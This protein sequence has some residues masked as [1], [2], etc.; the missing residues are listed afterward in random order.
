MASFAYVVSRTLFLRKK[1]KY[2]CLNLWD[3]SEWPLFSRK[4][5]GT[6]IKGLFYQKDKSISFSQLNIAKEKYTFTRF[7]IVY[8]I[9]AADGTLRNAK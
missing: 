4:R 9:Q 2:S 5:K 8:V 7:E 6:R 3:F 1:G